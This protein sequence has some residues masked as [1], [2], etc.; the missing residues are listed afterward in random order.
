MKFVG[1][2]AERLQKAEELS[3]VSQL[4]SDIV[5][6]NGDIPEE[7]D[8]EFDHNVVIDAILG[9][10]ES[11][12][13]SFQLPP[14][15]R[16]ASPRALADGTSAMQTCSSHDGVEVPEIPSM[17][18]ITPLPAKRKRSA[19]DEGTETTAVKVQKISQSQSM[20]ASILPGELR[21]AI[22][23]ELFG[24]F[25]YFI[26]HIYTTS[27]RQNLWN[28]RIFPAVTPEIQPFAFARTC[29]MFYSETS[30]LPYRFAGR[31]IFEDA[32][33]LDMF[34]QAGSSREL[35]E[36]S[37]IRIGS[38]RPTALRKYHNIHMYRWG[39][40]SGLKRLELTP[41][42][43]HK[44]I[45]ARFE[46]FLNSIF[47]DR[48]EKDRVQVETFRLRH[49]TAQIAGFRSYPQVPG[50]HRSNSKSQ[51]PVLSRL[52]A[53][54][55]HY[56]SL[57]PTRASQQPRQDIRHLSLSRRIGYAHFY[58]ED[59]LY[60]DIR[61]PRHLRCL[62]T[63]SP[64]RLSSAPTLHILIEM[65]APSLQ[66]R[67]DSFTNS[68]Y[69]VVR[70][71]H[72]APTAAWYRNEVR[73]VHVAM[74]YTIENFVIGFNLTPARFVILRENL[75]SLIHNVFVEK[76]CG[77]VSE[78]E[79]NTQYRIWQ[80]KAQGDNNQS[81]WHRYETTI[82]NDYMW[83]I[84]L[85]VKQHEYL[86]DIWTS[87][88]LDFGN[89]TIV[90]VPLEWRHQMTMYTI[91]NTI[92]FIIRI[93]KSGNAHPQFPWWPSF[94]ELAFNWERPSLAPAKQAKLH[95]FKAISIR[96]VDTL[97]HPKVTFVNITEL[98]PSAALPSTPGKSDISVEQVSFDILEEI[99]TS[100]S[101]VT[102]THETTSIMFIN[103]RSGYLPAFIQDSLCLQ[104][105]VRALRDY[106]ADVIQLQIVTRDDG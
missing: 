101:N 51:L 54:I 98:F 50:N 87:G 92:D 86:R 48:D 19:S 47:T 99:L 85:Q 42:G 68:S 41:K 21:N 65:A 45:K 91:T 105:A 16:P 61:P 22:Y 71:G 9:P 34:L 26:S 12:S 7:P 80:I 6:I 25:T 52:A 11:S 82:Y 81:Y 74:K 46:S 60:E 36:I 43:T 18:N 95:K 32:N 104:Y 13:S 93:S 106:G 55:S 24:G 62:E 2:L 10:P 59:L 57:I 77:D 96:I 38:S 75:V 31:F 84:Y 102:Y 70:G 5:L 67:E 27:T 103:P 23:E 66:E 28:T 37:T 14:T 83:P 73:G 79:R 40:L 39:M 94:P 76:T 88:H 78:E 69:H 20:L 15:R 8:D 90:N 72:P 49:L 30:L 63:L 53:V 97:H 29:R 100:D 33:D 58:S 3:N 35:A 89:G 1:A 17:L 56:D 4:M 44:D 64:P